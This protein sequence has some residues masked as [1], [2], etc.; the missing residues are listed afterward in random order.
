MKIILVHL[1]VLLSLFAFSQQRLTIQYNT[2]YLTYTGS[3]DA[4]SNRVY[5]WLTSAQLPAYTL[6]IDN[7]ISY[8]RNPAVSPVFKNDCNCYASVF[9]RDE[10]NFIYYP[11]PP[12]TEKEL[13]IKDSALGKWYFSTDTDTICGYN[14]RRAT[15]YSNGQYVD[16]WYAWDL[17]AGFGPFNYTGL[18]GT[19]L[20]LEAGSTTYVAT[21]VEQTGRNVEMPS[22]AVIDKETYAVISREKRMY[23]AGL[24]GKRVDPNEVPR[25][26]VIRFH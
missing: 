23:R 10:N 18:P 4:D 25:P 12:V 11:V 15:A 1:F 16:A 6:S 9:Y 2:A 22:V 14:C 7:K 5:A 19:I 3:I 17:P 20:K 21:A 13:M 8:F 26:M 24:L